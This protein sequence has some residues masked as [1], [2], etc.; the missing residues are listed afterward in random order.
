MMTNPQYYERFNTKVDVT[1]AISV[2]RQHKV[3]LEYVAQEIHT[4]AFDTLT[5]D[6]QTAVRMDAEERYLSY[7]FLHQ[8]GKQ[9]A[10]LRTDLQND[11]TTGD[12]CYP[13]NRQQT[14]HLL[15]K[16]SKLTA[17]KPQPSEGTAFAQEGKGKGGGKSNHDGF[18]KK[19]WKDKTCFQCNKKGHPASHCPAQKDQD[20]LDD[21]KSKGSTT[22][23]VKQ[24]EKEMKK[25]KKKHSTINAQLQQLHEDDSELSE[26]EAEEDSHFQSHF[27]F[28]QVEGTFEPQIEALLKQSHDSGSQHDLNLRMVW[29]LDSQS[30]MDLACNKEYI[31]DIRKSKQTMRLHSNG[32]QMNVDHK[33]TI[34]GYMH[35]VWFDADVITNIVSLKNIIQQY[36]V[37]YDSL[38]L[39]FVVHREVAGKPNMRFIMHKSGLH[40]FDPRDENFQFV[41]T[42][43][44]N[45]SNFTKR[46]VQRAEVAKSLYAKLS[47]PSQKDYRWIIQ[48]NQIKDCPVT[49]PDI[50]VASKIWGKDV[51]ALKG[52]T[53]W[54]KLSPVSAD[55]V[56]IPKELIKLHRDVYLT[57]DIFFVNKIP[58]FLTLSRKICFTTVNHLSSQEGDGDLLRFQGSLHILLAMWLPHHRGPC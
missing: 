7:V 24:L 43:S 55:Y 52:K 16:Y 41:M 26:S 54:T 2:T 15:D 4:Q 28:T 38:D 6:N 30:T 17:T 9:H 56:K 22:S 40:Y 50:Q 36:C 13:R 46:Q 21:T 29:L 10:T 58:F 39:A 8:S 14:L 51:D 49:V 12:N 35:H 27:Q 11:F 31:T 3:L 44:E 25:L 37:T 19:Y 53:T 18:D 48:S 45:K 5:A 23:S 42:V 47:Y 20:D 57:V 33:S 1:N 32:G 34:P